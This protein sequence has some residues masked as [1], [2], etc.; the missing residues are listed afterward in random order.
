[1]GLDPSPPPLYLPL[2]PM[3]WRQ[4]YFR[5]S[6]NLSQTALFQVGC[7]FHRDVENVRLIWVSVARRVTLLNDRIYF[8]KNELISFGFVHEVTLMK[9]SW[10]VLVVVRVTPIWLSRRISP[11]HQSKCLWKTNSVVM[12]RCKVELGSGWHATGWRR[13]KG[14]IIFI[15]HFS[16]K[17]PIIGGS[18]A[19]NDMQLEVSYGS[20]VYHNQGVYATLLRWQL[21]KTRFGYSV[22][23]F[24][25]RA[26]SAN[27]CV[28]GLARDW[29]QRQCCTKGW[30]SGKETIE[31][32]VSCVHVSFVFAAWLH[33]QFSL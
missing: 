8:V 7:F 21:N 19:E 5:M 2:P 3:S 24:H 11:F 33:T 32:G 17:S 22:T 18:F 15:C 4:T 14:N 28:G 23:Q 29:V 13:T 25:T 1:M 26:E 12:P 27:I 30:L 20:V 9:I 10:I 6:L 16:Q 31:Q